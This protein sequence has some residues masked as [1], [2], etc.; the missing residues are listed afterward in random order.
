MPIPVTVN[1]TNQTQAPDPY[2]ARFK[3][4]RCQCTMFT[5][6]FWK[7]SGTKDIKEST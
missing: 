3:C 1:V 4:I 7:K 5:G 6:Y 2:L